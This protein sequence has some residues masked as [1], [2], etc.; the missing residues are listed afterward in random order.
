MQSPT[1]VG[2]TYNL[3]GELVQESYTGGPLNG[4]SVTNGHD[5]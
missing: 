1:T 4:L 5:P 3:A 2:L